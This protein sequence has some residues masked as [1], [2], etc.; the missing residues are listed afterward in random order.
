MPTK[1]RKAPHKRY[2]DLI[3]KKEKQNYEQQA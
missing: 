1:R 3:S 2:I